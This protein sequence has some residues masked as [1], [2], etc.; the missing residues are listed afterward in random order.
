[1]KLEAVNIMRDL[2]GLTTKRPTTA[3]AEGAAQPAK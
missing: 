1:M 3:K 2:L